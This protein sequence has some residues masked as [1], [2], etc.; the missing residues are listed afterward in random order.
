MHGVEA[1]STFAKSG[2][3]IIGPN[4]LQRPLSV[5]PAVADELLSNLLRAE[6]DLAVEY[7]RRNDPCVYQS[8]HPADVDAL[9]DQGWEVQRRG[10]TRVRVRRAKPHDRLLEDDVWTLF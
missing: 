3:E 5:T 7:R 2:D 6:S 1:S 8:V 10:K 9:L 4:A